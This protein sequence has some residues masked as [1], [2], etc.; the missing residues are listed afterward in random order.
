MSSGSTDEQLNLPG[1]DAA[2]RYGPAGFAAA[3]VDLVVLEFLI[4]TALA[5]MYIPALVVIVP[6]LIVNAVV[7]FVLTKAGGTSAHIGRGM[8]S[9]CAAATVTLLLVGAGGLVVVIATYALG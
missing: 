5:L 4:L 7:A 6:V 3:I 1:D 9:A 2:A 8:L